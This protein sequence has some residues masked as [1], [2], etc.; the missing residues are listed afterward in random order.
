MREVHFHLPRVDNA[1]N[2]TETLIDQCLCE[3]I[4]KFGG[5]TLTEAQGFWMDNGKLYKE[6]VYRFT[7]ALTTAADLISARSIAIRYAV[8]MEQLA[9]YFVNPE[10]DVSIINLEPMAQ[11]GAM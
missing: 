3:I 4:A 10:G 7:V 11:S 2:S 1:G 5:A 6:P 8:Q 9:L